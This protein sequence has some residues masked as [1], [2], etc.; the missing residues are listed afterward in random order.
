MHARRWPAAGLILALLGVQTAVLAH[1]PLLA[2]RSAGTW[3][4]HAMGTGERHGEGS[5][6]SCR[7]CVALL[8]AKTSLPVAHG[9]SLARGP[10]ATDACPLLVTPA[11]PRTLARTPEGP[12]AP[13][14]AG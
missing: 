9:S 12:R 3:L 14:L 13:P 2:E 4:A 5:D 6:G 11:T 1:G 7:L 8:Q 10:E